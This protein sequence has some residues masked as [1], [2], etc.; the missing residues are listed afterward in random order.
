MFRAPCIAVLALSI[1]A[2]GSGSARAVS[3]P[4][5]LCQKTVVK[6]LERYK[7]AH[8]TRFRTCLDKEN[9]GDIPG[10]CLDAT[11]A[12]KLALTS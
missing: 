1:I 11:S 8:F 4:N 2:L 7:K 12:G 3:D 9:A 5:V 6:Q 10:P